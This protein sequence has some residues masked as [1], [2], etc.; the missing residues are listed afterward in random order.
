LVIYAGNGFGG[1]GNMV[2]VE[3]N[4]EWATLYGHLESIAVREG[5]I[6]KAGDPL[7][8][9]GATGHA[10]GVHLHFELMHNREPVDPLTLLTKGKKVAKVLPSFLE[11]GAFQKGNEYLFRLPSS[12]PDGSQDRDI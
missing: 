5:R 4:N 11:G 6:V 1:Y 2:L 3:Y 7:G 12:Q 10:T 8:G 9:M